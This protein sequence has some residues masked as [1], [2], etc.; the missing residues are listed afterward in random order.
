VLQFWKSTE[1]G[2]RVGASDSPS[3]IQKKLERDPD[4]FL[5]AE[6]DGALVGTVIG[7]FDGR[8]GFIYHLAV[9]AAFRRHGVASQLMQEAERR[10]QQ[11]GCIRAYLLV[12]PDNAGAQAYY[13]KTGWSVLDDVVFAKDFT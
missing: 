8:R 6:I 3:E 13:E 7:G 2:I 9:A 10:L 4:L 5:V 1:R 11:K 12:R